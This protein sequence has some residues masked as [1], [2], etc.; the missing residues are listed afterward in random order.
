VYFKGSTLSVGVYMNTIK[1]YKKDALAIAGSCTRTTKMPSQ[2]YSLPAKECITGSKL[3][4]VKG[5]VCE[6]C[7]ALK[8]NYHRY[9]KTIEPAQY[10]RLESIQHPL[11]VQS[12]VK[13]IGN[14]PFFRW[15]DSGDLQSVDHLSKIASIA[16]QLPKTLFWLP[17]R[18]YDIVKDFV[19]T[20]SIPVNLVIRM[21]AIMID[22]PAKL[23]RSLKGFANILTSTVHSKTELDGFKCKAPS[24]EG[25]CGSC[26]ACWDNTVTNVSYH[27]H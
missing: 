5:S 4:N 19:K 25:K 22:A 10:K 26:R 14:K 7:Y 2:S 18:E 9:A 12:M 11:W 17:T 13:L 15:H 8:G 1:F 3:V 27:V 20:E 23:P 16:R 6:G 24:Q 21:S